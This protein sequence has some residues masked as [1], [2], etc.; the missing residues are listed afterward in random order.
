MRFALICIW[1]TEIDKHVLMR[2]CA[3]ELREKEGSKLAGKQEYAK[4]VAR[5][6]YNYMCVS[7]ALQDV[8]YQSQLCGKGI[9]SLTG[10]WGCFWPHFE[11]IGESSC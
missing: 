10:F 2:Y 6:L 9:T 1:V 3:A 11:S 4:L 7:P 5:D 8:A